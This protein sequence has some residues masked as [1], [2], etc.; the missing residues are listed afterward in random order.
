MLLIHLLVTTKRYGILCIFQYTGVITITEIVT[1]TVNFF[2]N[3]K[4]RHF[5]TN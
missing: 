1:N 4:N 5:S 2:C 3:N